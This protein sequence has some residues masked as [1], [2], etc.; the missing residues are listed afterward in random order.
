MVPGSFLSSRGSHIRVLAVVDGE[1]YPPVVARAFEAVTARGDEIVGA[2]LA[3]GVEKLPVEGIDEIAGVRLITGEDVA[4]TLDS[5]LASLSPDAVVDLS[6]EPVL[7]NRKRFGLAA[8]TL[9]HGSS[10]R[11]AGML[12]EP[13]PRPRLCT[14]PSIAVIG[15]GKRTGKTAVSGHL[16]R[17]L[18]AA[19]MSPIVVAMGRGG[20]AEPAVLRGDQ[21]ELDAASLLELSD[22]GA[23]AASDYVEDALLSRVKTVGCW[24]CGGGPAGAVEHTNLAAGIEAANALE[25]DIIILEGSGASIP[26]AF[27]DSTLLISPATISEENLLGYL[28]M[29]RLLLADLAVVTMCE[30]PFGSPSQIDSVVSRIHGS[31]RSQTGPDG[32]RPIDVVRTVFRPKPLRSV[33]GSKVAVATTAPEA[34]GDQIVRHLEE[35][36]GC[37]VIAITHGLSNRKTLTADLGA[38]PDVDLLLCE[39]KAAAVDVAT[40]W[41]VDRGIDVVYMDNDPTPVGDDDLDGSLLGLAEKARERYGKKN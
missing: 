28:G 20:P 31:F 13:P 41:A 9:A 26:P 5:A 39:V 37:K 18:V 1:H 25:G 16:A 33:A 7:D 19:G 12:L 8:L 10:Y 23:H 15:T 14:M 34:V 40:R 2:V 29:Y 36:H 4:A 17:A 11:S 27:A 35:E 32:G 22:S 3:G 6:D 24:R 38:N 30:E 21:I